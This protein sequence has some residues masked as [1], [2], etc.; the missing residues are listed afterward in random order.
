M[1]Q[2]AAK[3][4]CRSAANPVPAPQISAVGGL[5]EIGFN[6]LIANRFVAL[7]EQ[8]FDGKSE[9]FRCRQRNCINARGSVAPSRPL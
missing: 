5:G 7:V 4:R 6:G 9:I 3:F 8:N 1:P 2:R